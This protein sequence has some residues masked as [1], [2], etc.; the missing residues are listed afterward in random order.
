MQTWIWILLGIVLL[1]AILVWIEVYRELHRFQTVTYEIE[2]EKIKK[3]SG[4]LKIVFLSDLHN[5][6]YGNDNEELLSE[7][8]KA[9]PDYIFIGGDMLVGRKGKHISERASSFIEQLPEIAPV[10]Y[11]NGNHEQRM[12]EQIAHYENAY[13]KYK[14]NLEKSGVRWLEDETV[15][16]FWK[17]ENICLSGTEIPM[18][19]YRRPRKHWLNQKDMEER[20]GSP[21]K[22]KYQILLAHHPDYAKVYRQ[23]GSDLTL[24]G[25]LHGGVAR[26]PLLGGVISP[27]AGLF[28]KY[29]GDCYEVDG[30]H[31]VVSKGLGTHTVNIRFWNPAELVVLHIKGKK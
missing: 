29:S 18:D 23:W 31:I 11:A 30:G 28:P 24:S 8:K 1:A 5:R 10:Y 4:I 16:L 3:E 6:V 27:Q 7:I 17:E 9:E 20:L 21:N 15:K 26:L 22:E 14:K 12:H 25:H 2:T 13:E 19:C